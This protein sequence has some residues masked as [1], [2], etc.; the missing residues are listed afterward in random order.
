MVG[1]L[2]RSRTSRSMPHRGRARTRPRSCRCEIR[3][4]PTRLRP[5]AP[6]AS[7]S[8]RVARAC[9]TS[10]ASSA[11]RRSRTAWRAVA[12]QAARRGARRV[13]LAPRCDRSARRSRRRGSART[14][15]RQAQDD[16]FEMCRQRPARMAAGGWRAGDFRVRRRPAEQLPGDADGAPPFVEDIEHI[17]VAEVDLHRAAA[18]T[19]AVVALEVAI[20]ARGTRSSAARPAAAQPDTTSNDGPTTRIR[21]PSFF[22]HR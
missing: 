1:S 19:L 8:S 4:A 3:P 12:A 21:W 6:R 15:R 5:P 16:A 2:S 18:R 13:E 7:P 9:C 17:G 22:W 10:S 20:D 14:R 11:A